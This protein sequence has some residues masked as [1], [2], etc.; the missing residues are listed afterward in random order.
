MSRGRWLGVACGL[1]VIDGG[2]VGGRARCRGVGC[3]RDEGVLGR[4]CQGGV[5]FLVGHTFRL[6]CRPLAC[7]RFYYPA[8]S[9]I[10]PLDSVSALLPGP[11]CAVSPISRLLG[12]HRGKCGVQV[13]P[14]KNLF[15]SRS[16]GS[17]STR[18]SAR[19]PHL[20]PVPGF[21]MWPRFHNKTARDTCTLLAVLASRTIIFL[22]FLASLPI[23]LRRDI[24]ESR[25]QLEVFRRAVLLLFIGSCY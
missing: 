14:H 18:C 2:M 12:A 4:R 5:C 9:I 10:F 7:K 24:L 20:V 11:F 25:F 8:S 21:N 16:F 1:K 6:P 19:A 17:R 15:M 13:Y 23:K 3:R 22:F